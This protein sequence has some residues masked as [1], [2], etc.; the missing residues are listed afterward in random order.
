MLFSKTYCKK[1]AGSTQILSFLITAAIRMPKLTIA[2]ALLV[3][4]ALAGTMSYAGFLV[5]GVLAA[6]LGTGRVM[7]SLI[8]AAV[9][10]RFPWV[11]KGRLRIVGLLPKPFR[12]PLIVSLLALCVLTLSSR[13]EYLS[14]FFPGFAAAFLLAYPWLRRAVFD[15]M[16]SPVF[17]SAVVKKLRKSKDDMVIDA[18]F[19]ERKE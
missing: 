11:S 5:V 2:L 15:R 18:E 3:L 4:A 17:K 1:S 16:F 8:L 19:K 7:A 9:F 14:A 10:A 13:G 6:H 12:R